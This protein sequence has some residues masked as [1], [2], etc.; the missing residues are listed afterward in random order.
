MPRTAEVAREL[1]VSERTARRDLDALRDPNDAFDEEDMQTC[2]RR[3]NM[4]LQLVLH[5]NNNNP[6]AAFVTY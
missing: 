1:E 3:G 5:K 4:R 2:D 6:L